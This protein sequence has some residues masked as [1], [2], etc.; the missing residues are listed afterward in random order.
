[1]VGNISGR[2]RNLTGVIIL[3]TQTSVTREIPPNCHK[4]Q[5]IS[6]EGWKK[7]GADQL[8]LVYPSS[9]FKIYKVF[10]HPSCC[11]ISSINSISGRCRE[12]N[13]SPSFVHFSTIEIWSTGCHPKEFW[14]RQR[15]KQILP[16]PVPSK[17]RPHDAPHIQPL[18]FA[19]CVEL[20]GIS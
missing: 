19:V 17:T 6:L 3:P 5:G 20:P 4:W 12:F 7:S 16:H 11:R 10:L 1:M 9:V 14:A 15:N 13:L 8:I 2:C 18:I